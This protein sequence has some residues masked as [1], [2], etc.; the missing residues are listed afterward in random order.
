MRLFSTTKLVW[1]LGNNA[2]K[3]TDSVGIWSFGFCGIDEFCQK[4]VF[5]FVVIRCADLGILFWIQLVAGFWA[6]V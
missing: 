6:N 2:G 5:R 4:D 1:N 3:K